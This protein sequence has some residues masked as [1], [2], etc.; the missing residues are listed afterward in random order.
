[1]ISIQVRLV[2]LLFFLREAQRDLSAEK[3]AE[4]LKEGAGMLV[5]PLLRSVRCWSSVRHDRS[6]TC[7][8]AEYHE[9][10]KHWRLS[11]PSK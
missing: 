1:M 3:Q 2:A 9:E 4:L 5:L 8:V 10:W 11:W 6:D 7:L